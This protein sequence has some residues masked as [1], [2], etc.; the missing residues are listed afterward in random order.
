MTG[1]E[2]WI[3]GIGSNRSTNWATTIALFWSSVIYELLPLLFCIQKNSPLPDLEPEVALMISTFK[4]ATWT[5]Q[6]VAVQR[7]PNI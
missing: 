5:A 6:L 2:L 1:F 4:T 3:S 7:R